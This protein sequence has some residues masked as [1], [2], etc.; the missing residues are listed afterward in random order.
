[1]DHIKNSFHIYKKYYKLYIISNKIFV[2]LSGK[3]K[4]QKMQTRINFAVKLKNN[5][6][7]Y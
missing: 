1:M 2:I 7:S 5:I 3:S 4:I 6:E